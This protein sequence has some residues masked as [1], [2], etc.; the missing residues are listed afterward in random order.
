MFSNFF[1]AS[2]AV[3]LA[4][5]IFTFINDFPSVMICPDQEKSQS[6]SVF[7]SNM[8]RA[9]FTIFETRGYFSVLDSFSD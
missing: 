6:M 8:Q 5:S 9:A 4:L 7:P 1:R 3:S 2:E